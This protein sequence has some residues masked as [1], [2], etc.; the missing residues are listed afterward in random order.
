M[1]KPIADGLIT[2]CCLQTHACADWRP[3]HAPAR[4]LVSL[5]YAR[6]TNRTVTTPTEPLTMY[7]CEI[8]CRRVAR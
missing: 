2:D 5:I 1:P 3:A 4:W 7:A 8:G 6:A